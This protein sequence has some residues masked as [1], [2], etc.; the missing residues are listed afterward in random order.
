MTCV[1]C[2]HPDVRESERDCPRC[3]KEC[4][5]PNVR[6]AN[7]PAEVNALQAR[8]DAGRRDAEARA[9]AVNFDAYETAVAGSKIVMSRH[10]KAA[11]QLLESDN[12][13]WV[14]FYHQTGAGMRRP[15]DTEVEGDR[16]VADSRLFPHYKQMICFAVLSLNELGPPYYGR[17]SLTFE[18]ALLSHRTSVFEENSVKFLGRHGFRLPPGY[19][20][21]WPARSKLAA[22]KA[23]PRITPSASARDFDE[24]L[25]TQ[26]INAADPDFIE[27]HIFGAIHHSAIAKIRFWPIN[28]KRD[29]PFRTRIREICKKRKIEVEG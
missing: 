27:V 5:Y 2:G 13:M 7:E 15:E 16:G 9:A 25:M 19:R 11:L 20:A 10:E 26:D 23:A 17:C 3:G 24:L 29:S 22:A 18:E 28:Q 4:G 8:L 6:K 1:H 21:P 14:S 12:A